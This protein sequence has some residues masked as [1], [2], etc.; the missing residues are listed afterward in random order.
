MI[1]E[2]I[3][4]TG[5]TGSGGCRDAFAPGIR[6]VCGKASQVE[7]RNITCQNWTAAADEMRLTSLLSAKVQKPYYHLVLSWHETEHPTEA[8]QISAMDQ[9][10]QSL[11]LSEHQVVIATHRDTPRCHVH[12]VVNLVHPL[13]GKVWSKS[14]DRRKA[15]LACRRIELMMGW[16]HDRG[17]FDF[18]VAE[19][20]G[21]RTVK[22]VKKPRKQA[23]EEREN[24]RRKKTSSQIKTEKRTGIE[25]FDH[26]IPEALKKK[27]GQTIDACRSW[28]EVHAAFDDLGLRY[29][30][31][32]S[33]ARIYLSG[34]TEY[35]KASSFGAR[36][37]ISRMEKAFG[38][39]EA[40][41]PLPKPLSEPDPPCPCGLTGTTSADDEK[42]VSAA[43]FK[44]TL[45]RRI[46][47]EIHIDPRVAREI[48][49]VD[50]AGKPPK[51]TFR[52]G[53]IVT[54]Q[55]QELATSVSSPET[56]ATMIAMAKAKGWST[57]RPSGSAAFIR[58]FSIDAA[59]AGL[60]V[61]GV[62]A[63][64]QAEAD[65]IYQQHKVKPPFER[66]ARAVQKAHLDAQS[67]RE[68]AIRQNSEH[69][70]Q[71]IEQKR[72]AP[73]AM[74]PDARRAPAPQPAPD[75]ARRDKI[76][77][78]RIRKSVIEDSQTELEQLK[79][80]DIGL[81][82]SAGG[83]SDVSHSHPDSSDR[84]GK[85]FRI[86]Q[87]G[88][89]TIKCSL[90]PDGRWLWVSNK[91]GNR[92]TVLDLWMQDNRGATLGHARLALRGFAGSS[93]VVTREPSRSSA[94]E[95][96]HT[97][98]R[99]RWDEAALITARTTYAEERGISKPTLARFSNEVRCGVFGGIYVAHRDFKTGSILGFEQRWEQNGEKNKARFAK[100]GRKSAAV[101]GD[102]RRASR[103]VV[104]E[105]GLDALALAEIE[106]RH[107]TIYAS[108]GGGF[109][110]A[111]DRA[112]A[113]LA[114]GRE[115]LSGF[116]NDRA[117]EALHT[118]LTTLLPAAQRL[119]P[120]SRVPGSDEDCKDWLDVLN[121]MK[122]ARWIGPGLAQ[123]EEPQDNR[124]TPRPQ[125]PDGDWDTGQT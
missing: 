76:G 107:D 97:S 61:A 111:T 56:R 99:Q 49:F 40:A 103:L 8:Q 26:T 114:Q 67:D 18:A 125:M 95:A 15:E 123:T 5:E 74:L 43:A 118:H 121:A 120:P 124:N 11:T 72:Q 55:G 96:D 54:D 102:A 58:S 87:R 41:K 45:L 27:L 80:L 62:P 47:T 22:L 106:N 16:P 9:L 83:W 17:H 85:A 33:G 94:P 109:G 37:S 68:T 29:E 73:S 38:R 51:I 42:M 93:P 66:A 24:G 52:S 4:K 89:E 105:S 34:S 1:C 70:A 78:R 115:I 63:E 53:A 39:F 75:A 117:G 104:V 116:D 64:V 60:R 30:R 25:V 110:A 84:A 46:Y 23:A 88:T 82:A 2:I 12:A 32:G 59:R 98:V 57:L 14:N 35:A 100:G 122:N 71:L 101:F 44:T 50:L 19:A 13:S 119:A 3:T 21:K 92:G 112:L 65:R 90:K 69:R 113:H 81:I 28:P 10:L 6:Y 7:L 48:R 31:F 36:F 77:V 91:T 86:Y 108:T 20:E 79:R